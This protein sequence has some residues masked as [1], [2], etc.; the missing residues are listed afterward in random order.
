[1][2]KPYKTIASLLGM[3][4]I[5]SV[6]IGLEN[7]IYKLREISRKEFSS[8]LSWLVPANIAVLLLAGLLL[9]WLWFVYSKEQDSRVIAIVYVLVGLGL[10]FYNVVA[11]ALSPNLPLPVRLMRFP[12]SFTAFTSAV[13]VVA[14]LQKLFSRKAL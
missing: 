12:I 14:G 1:M 4:F 10:L 9:V 6:A 7:W 8:V 13:F 2:K 3:F 11:I 5:F